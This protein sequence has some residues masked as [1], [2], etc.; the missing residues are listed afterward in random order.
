MRPTVI[1]VRFAWLRRA[2]SSSGTVI[3][4]MESAGER[5]DRASAAASREARSRKNTSH[6]SAVS[7]SWMAVGSKSSRAP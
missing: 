4:V 3:G 2:Q 7:R 6:P 5:P 1:A